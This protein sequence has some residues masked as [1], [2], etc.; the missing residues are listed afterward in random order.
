[1]YLFCILR[2]DD[3]QL[4]L[5]FFSPTA[6]DAVLTLERCLGTILEWIR[7]NGLRSNPDKREILRVG[8]PDVSGLGSSLSFGGKDTS[9]KE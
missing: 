7:A 6:V 8:G 3:T 4:Y 2:A 1:M 5:S 9:H